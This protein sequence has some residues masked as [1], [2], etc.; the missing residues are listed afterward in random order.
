MLTKFEVK[1]YAG[2]EKTITFDLTSK[3]KIDYNK[4]FVEK[5]IIKILVIWNIHFFFINQMI[6]NIHNCHT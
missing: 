3:R 2:F 1:N 5:G 4:N 6:C